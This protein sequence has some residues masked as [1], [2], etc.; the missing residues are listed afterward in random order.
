MLRE[1]EAMRESQKEN[2]LKKTLKKESHTSGRVL[3]V[4]NELFHELALAG[5]GES[6]HRGNILNGE[7]PLSWS[8]LRVLL[9]DGALK[10][11]R[12]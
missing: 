6:R 8:K 4:G 3:G 9:L 10:V 12:F 1:R 5:F 7:P 11:S 2:I